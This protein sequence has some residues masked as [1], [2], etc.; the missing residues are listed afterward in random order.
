[1]MRP[2]IYALG[3]V[4]LASGALSAE[5]AQRIVSAGGSITEI[6]YALGQEH[7]LVARD[8]T[9]NHPAEVSE[10]PSVGYVRR[11]SA[12]GLLSVNPDLILTEEG[13]GPP[14]TLEVLAETQIPLVSVPMGHDREAVITKIRTV[15]IALDMPEEG[16]ELAARIGA[17]I[18]AASEQSDLAEKRVLFVLSIQGARVLAGGSNTA[19]QGIIEM[20]GA[21]NAVEG[22]EGYKPLGD[23]A[24]ITAAPDVILMMDA[25]TA[26]YVTDEEVLSHPAIAATPAGQNKRVLRMD[27]MLLLGFS[28]RTGQAIIDLAAG[29]R[30]ANG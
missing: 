9:S 21:I 29:L 11:L 24:I 13:A 14:E 26:M 5:P 2:Y 22:F 8:S 19:S 4:F 10:L 6:I 30:G 20:A 18:D 27:G 15:A 17:A 16:E 3:F 1:M 25:G 12:E 23:E 28:V 7:R